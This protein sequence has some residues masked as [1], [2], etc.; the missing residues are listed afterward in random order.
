ML[1]K[2]RLKELTTNMFIINT[3]GYIIYDLST[4]YVNHRIQNVKGRIILKWIFE[5]WD[6]RAWTGSIW[7]MIGTAGKHL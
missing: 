7:L 1:F 3:V 2:D 4:L 6:E 5:K